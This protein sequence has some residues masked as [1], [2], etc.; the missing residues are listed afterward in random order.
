MGIRTSTK[1][2]TPA[3]IGMNG[4]TIRTL[5]SRGKL[6]LYI[7]VNYIPNTIHISFIF[8]SAILS[9]IF[10]SDHFVDLKQSLTRGSSHASRS[11]SLV[12]LPVPLPS[13][14]HLSNKTAFSATKQETDL[15]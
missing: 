9:G 13:S 8:L 15:D 3:H 10:Y 4:G 5:P 1:Q 7:S 14:F 6:S 12:L 2:S 11:H